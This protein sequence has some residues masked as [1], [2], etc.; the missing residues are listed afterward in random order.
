MRVIWHNHAHPPH[1]LLEEDP[2]TLFSAS[3]HPLF[4]LMMA[5]F[6]SSDE[7]SSLRGNTSGWLVDEVRV[8]SRHPF[9]RYSPYGFESRR[10][11]IAADPSTTFFGQIRT[12]A[13]LLVS[14]PFAL[15]LSH[16]SLSL[17]R[18]LLLS[19]SLILSFWRECVCLRL[20]VPLGSSTSSGT[21]LSV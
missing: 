13:C 5:S 1:T 15:V 17:S 2:L 16:P 11:K 6:N 8:R 3:A 21:V 12:T 14:T 9:G 19:L 4:L 10:T 18:P 7:S 20:A